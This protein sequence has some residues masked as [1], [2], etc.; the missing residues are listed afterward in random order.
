M[1]LLSYFLLSSIV[2]LQQCYRTSPHVWLEI[3]AI[4]DIKD[5]LPHQE[6]LNIGVTTT[7]VFGPFPLGILAHF[8]DRH[9]RYQSPL[10]DGGRGEEGQDDGQGGEKIKESLEERLC[11]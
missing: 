11:C 4:H 9:L 1:D 10:R 7:E 8:K 2:G 6:V 3:K 5:S